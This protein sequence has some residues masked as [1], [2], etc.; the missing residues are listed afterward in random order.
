MINQSVT[1]RFLRYV[2]IDTQADP[3]SKTIPSSNKQ[4]NLSKIL[5]KELSDLGISNEL[6]REGY[7]YASIKSNS[8]K[9]NVPTIFFCAHV[10][11][12]PDC[13]GTDVKPIIHKNYQGQ[14]IV[15]PDDN[16]QVI[17]C[18]KF[19]ELKNKLGHD[20]ISASGQT[21]LGA[22]DK[23]GVACIMTAVQTLQNNHDIIH[24]EVKILFTTDEEIGR[25][26]V[27]VDLKKI[28]A[29]FGYTL[30]SGDVG[31]FESENFSANSATLTI[32]G[33]SAHPG[34]AKGK[35]QNA[36]KII[37]EILTALPKDYLTPE[38]TSAREGFI[39]PGKISGELE[40][41]SINFILRDF[42]T[43]NLDNQAELIKQTTEKILKKY[44]NSSYSL[45]VREQYRNMKDVISKHPHVIEYAREA[46]ANIGIEEKIGVIRGGTDGAILS[47]KGLPCPNI[48]SGQHGIHSKLEWTT[49]QDMQAAVDTI[50][51][52]CK[53]TERKA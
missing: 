9:K 17:C 47:H 10:D 4:L 24:G 33:V 53:I 34:Y 50:V 18:E 27:A 29:D 51:E 30:D 13:S 48:F 46:M 2:Q 6:T 7:V 31:H 49:S 22:D 28:N 42:N 16:S 12:A 36:I 40:T 20:I 32:K 26:V 3:E 19:P 15:L 23:S 11:T 39:H 21:L 25:G 44:P 37:S 38:S 41:A 1:E 35:M 14:D 43:A 52:I 8:T 45:I 5:A